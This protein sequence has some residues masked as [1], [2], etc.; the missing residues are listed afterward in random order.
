M[1]P[2]IQIT[3]IPALRA[4]IKRARDVL[5]RPRF[6][7]SE[8]WVKITKVEAEQLIARLPADA[9]PDTSEMFCDYFATTTTGRTLFLG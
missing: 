4:A 3:T 5:V 8:A 7:C 1:T 6:G 2:E 9:T